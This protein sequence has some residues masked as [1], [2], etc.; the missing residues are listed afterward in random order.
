MWGTW[1]DDGDDRREHVTL[2]LI[3]GI[4]AVWAGITAV[5]LAA[6]VLGAR[7]D[8][9]TRRGAPAI[10]RLAPAAPIA[11]GRARSGRLARV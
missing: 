6:C 5:V 1:T 2:L 8:R 9:E 3:I 4:L 7:A 11:P 10:I